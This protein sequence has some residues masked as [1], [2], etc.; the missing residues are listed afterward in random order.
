MD[1][2]VNYYELNAKSFFSA[3]VSADLS[4]LRTKFLAHVPVHGHI[5]DAGCG[6]GRDAKA[7]CEEGFR[8]TAFDA[9][10]A[11][12]KLAAR[13]CGF[14]VRVRTF[15]EMDEVDMYDG[16]WCC[17]SLLHV[18]APDVSATLATLWRALKPGG[19]LYVS[20]KSGK[21]EHSMEGRIFTDADER[22]LRGWLADIRDIGLTEIW[23]T[24][25]A[26][27]GRDEQWLNAIIAKSL[28]PR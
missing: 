17:A 28:G 7:F 26:L 18:P 3:T 15:E 27:P 1:N 11:V 19:A 24:R 12:A 13:Y 5:L 25:D 23:Q 14:P 4:S 8:V 10:S 22:R 2:N 16:I 20:F 21:G 9:S 6:S